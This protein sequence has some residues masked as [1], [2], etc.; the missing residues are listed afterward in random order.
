MCGDL[1][2]AL[3]YLELDGILRGKFGRYF[4]KLRVI[5]LLGM[6]MNVRFSNVI[7]ESLLTSLCKKSIFEEFENNY[8][9]AFY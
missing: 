9:K 7:E 6:T 5:K 8:S 1:D 4:D 3:Y 2:M